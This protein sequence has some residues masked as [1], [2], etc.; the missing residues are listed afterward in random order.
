VV[1]WRESAYN[2]YSIRLHG[3]KAFILGLS[4]FEASDVMLEASC[5]LKICGFG[6]IAAHIVAEGYTVDCYLVPLRE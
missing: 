1:S 4:Q 5:K 6:E 3:R 2:D